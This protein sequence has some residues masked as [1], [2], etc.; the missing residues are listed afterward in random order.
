MLHQAGRKKL[1]DAEIN[2]RIARQV[3]AEDDATK[4]R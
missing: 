1:S 2:R 3:L 4:S